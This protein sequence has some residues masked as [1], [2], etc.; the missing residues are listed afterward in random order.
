MARLLSC[1]KSKDPCQN[2]SLLDQ[3]NS[4]SIV[5]PAGSKPQP[6]SLAQEK[7]QIRAASLHGNCQE[8]QEGHIEHLLVAHVCFLEKLPVGCFLKCLLPYCQIYCS[9][10]VS[11]SPTNAKE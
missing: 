3:Y 11:F 2:I 5:K 4:S 8:G 7:P 9:S 6:E 1:G 10:P